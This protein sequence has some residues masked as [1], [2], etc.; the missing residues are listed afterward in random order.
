MSSTVVQSPL[1]DTPLLKTHLSIGKEI[2]VIDVISKYHL[3][4]AAV[5]VGHLVGALKYKPF[6]WYNDPYHSDST[7]DNN[8]NAIYRHL[9]AYE[10]GY[11][12]DKDSGLPQLFHVACRSAMLLGV[13]VKYAQVEALPQITYQINGHSFGG[14]L[15]GCEYLALAEVGSQIPD[16]YSD[17]SAAI[18]ELHQTLPMIH[19]GKS[20]KSTI[21]LQYLTISPSIALEFYAAIQ[22]VI[23]WIHKH[24]VAIKTLHEYYSSQESTQHIAQYIDAEMISHL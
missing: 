19:D 21:T 22:A 18:R 14:L 11:A 24:P 16:G 2:R 9:T 3:G 6:S 7:I 8:I 10:M 1:D 17:I 15:L 20:K 13:A 12:Y 5:E 4:L 23:I